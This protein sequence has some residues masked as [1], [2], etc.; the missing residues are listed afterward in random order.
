MKK[1]IFK[2]N[3]KESLI[4]VLK[5]AGVEFNEKDIERG[6]SIKWFSVVWK[7]EIEL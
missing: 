5:K 2:A 3:S 1:V 7:Y 4:L 6:F